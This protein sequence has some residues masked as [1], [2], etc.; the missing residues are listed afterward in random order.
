MNGL[1]PSAHKAMIKQIY[2]PAWQARGGYYSCV[3]QNPIIYEYELVCVRGVGG[4][5]CASVD[6]VFMQEFLLTL[7]EGGESY[8]KYELLFS[9]HTVLLDCVL[10]A[11]FT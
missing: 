4:G 5:D 11:S 1:I 6:A 9:L 7:F 3:V 10:G 8:V 2:G